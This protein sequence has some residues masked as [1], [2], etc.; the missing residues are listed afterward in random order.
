[1]KKVKFKPEVLKIIR[2]YDGDQK[3]INIRLFGGYQRYAKEFDV[4]YFIVK[5]GDSLEYDIV[6][7]KELNEYRVT[8]V[9]IVECLDFEIKLDD[10]LWNI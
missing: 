1:M 5:E 6:E 4:P 7:P 10:E 3:W 2:E 8:K 9:H